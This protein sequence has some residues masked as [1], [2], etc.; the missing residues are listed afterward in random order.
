MRRLRVAVVVLVAAAAVAAVVAAAVAA[1]VAAAVAAVVVAAW[2]WWQ[3]APSLFQRLCA[4]RYAQE[5]RLRWVW[6]GQQQE[7]R[8]W[9]QA[10]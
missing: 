7:Q 10:A 5:R 1:V 9:W 8:R 2:Q 4:F 3:A 6:P